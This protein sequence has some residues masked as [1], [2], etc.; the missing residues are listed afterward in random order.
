[1]TDN[2]NKN[3]HTEIPVSSP[4]L[5]VGFL[6]MLVL[7]FL[8]LSCGIAAYVAWNWFW[9]AFEFGPLGP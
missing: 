3:E 5:G 8:F 6:M 7:A 1:M 4:A 2:C 9:S